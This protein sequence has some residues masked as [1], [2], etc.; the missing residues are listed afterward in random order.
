MTSRTTVVIP[1]MDKPSVY[2]VFEYFRDFKPDLPIV[3]VDM[4]GDVAEKMCSRYPCKYLSDV[5]V[6]SISGQTYFNKSVAI[7]IGAYYVKT[8]SLLIC[9]GDVFINVQALDNWLLSTQTQILL[10]LESVLESD[11]S[12]T[13]IGP[14]ICCVS[15]NDFRAAKGYCSD[16]VG[17]GFEDHDFNDRLAV[18]GIEKRVTGTGIHLSHNDIERVRHYPSNDRM[19]MRAENL[20]LYEKRRRDGILSGSLE[21]DLMDYLPNT[22]AR[23]CSDQV[24]NT[25]GVVETPKMLIVQTVTVTA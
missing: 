25:M 11:G 16:F 15:L 14:G 21:R 4:G 17:W 5:T 8:E 24:D 23:R 20:S 22:I 6:V 2:Q 12:G 1:V 9:D 3:I 18:M 19:A 13:R 7:N 10:V